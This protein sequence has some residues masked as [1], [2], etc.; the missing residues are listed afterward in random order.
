MTLRSNQLAG[1]MDDWLERE[2]PDGEIAP[3]NVGNTLRSGTSRHRR[4]KVATQ[5]WNL[6]FEG[7][8]RPPRNQRGQAITD[9]SLRQLRLIENLGSCVHGQVHLYDFEGEVEC[10][11]GIYGNCRLIAKTIK[12]M[13][14][15]RL[16]GVLDHEH[17]L[18]M[19][20]LCTELKKPILAF[21][22]A[23]ECGD[24][25][26]FLSRL[27]NTPSLSWLLSVA[28]QIASGMNYLES[29]GLVHKDL[30][31]RNCLVEREG[32]IKISDLAMACEQYRDDY[33][34]TPE[35]LKPLRWWPWD[36]ILSGE[37]T[38]HSSVWSFGVTLWEILTLCRQKPLHLIA[39]HQLSPLAEKYGESTL[40]AVVNKEVSQVQVWLPKPL[41]S[42]PE[43]F[44]LMRECWKRDGSDRPTFQNIHLFLEQKCANSAPIYQSIN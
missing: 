14:E 24:L 41:L 23:P 42:P 32:S 12:G 18:E 33:C 34:H 31:A 29:L 25:C 27:T 11:Q 22:P 20:C 7:N 5:T 13:S 10:T 37:F 26:S 3:Q 35:G 6:C 38:L 28:A 36:A 30:A 9:V 43:I 15:I 19:I 2:L 21:Y 1:E 17:V 44:D 4:N 8:G 16:L 40:A 39:D